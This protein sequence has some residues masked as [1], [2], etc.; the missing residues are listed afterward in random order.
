MG[1]YC[2]K[3]G[4]ELQ[5][6]IKFC[7]K[8]GAAVQETQPEINVAKP[9]VRKKKVNKM[10]II[11]GAVAAVII[12]ACVALISG[13]ISNISVPDYEKPLK[14]QMDGI[15]KNDTKK[16]IDSLLETEKVGYDTEYLMDSMK[17]VKSVSYNVAE[18]KKMSVSSLLGT[19]AVLGF[20]MKDVQDAMTLVV[21]LNYRGTDGDGSRQIEFDVVKLNDKWYAVTDLF[22]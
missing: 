8:C 11:I 15:N 22:N 7:K 9:T 17:E 12:I 18:T 14:A 16:Y 6:G 1:K 3:C 2:S 10:R 20:S 21:D 5:E 4:N 19:G 13:V